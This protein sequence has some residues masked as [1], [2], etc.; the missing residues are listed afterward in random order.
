MK[1]IFN[2]EKSKGLEKEYYKYFEKYPT[3]YFEQETVDECYQ[4]VRKEIEER[5]KEFED[6][7]K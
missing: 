6:T 5:K 2:D 7:Q 3:W 1:Q 4:R